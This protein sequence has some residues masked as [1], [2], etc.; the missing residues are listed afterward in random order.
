MD[1]V[2]ILRARYRKMLFDTGNWFDLTRRL[3]YATTAATKEAAR[4]YDVGVAIA[5]DGVLQG[6]LA[7]T[8]GLR[9]FNV[10]MSRFGKGATWVPLDKIEKQDINGKKVIVFDVD[11]VTG[12][13][14]KR[15]ARELCAFNPTGLDLLLTRQEV[16][17]SKEE[18]QDW[19]RV[20]T[21]KP[22]LEE[23]GDS[24]VLDCKTM[25]PSEFQKVKTIH[26]YDSQD[27][28]AYMEFCDLVKR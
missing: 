13:T 5:N 26:T 15:A 20:F 6:Y 7:E 21:K 23:R 12:R 2:D 14:L 17:L 19:R 8:F 22:V 27:P 24:Y 16:T 9:T 28:L 10:K 4:E 11:V 18:Y 3:V 1:S 25:V